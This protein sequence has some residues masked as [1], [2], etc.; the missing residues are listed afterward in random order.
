MVALSCTHTSTAMHA[1]LI[2]LPLTE[3]QTPK[4][5]AAFLYS[6]GSLFSSFALFVLYLL[7]KAKKHPIVSTADFPLLVVISVATILA[8]LS[9]FPGATYPPTRISCFCSNWLKQFI[10]FFFSNFYV[11]AG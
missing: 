3:Y 1:G 10:F 9:L 7:T 11:C 5:V 8:Y 4:F 6:I 2:G